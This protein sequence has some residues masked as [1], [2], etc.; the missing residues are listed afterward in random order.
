MSYQLEILATDALLFLLLVGIVG[1]IFY[2]RKHEHLK[3]P[4]RQV[5][6]RPMAMSALIVL[7]VYSAIGILDSIHLRVA[8][9][10]DAREAQLSQT[11]GIV[12]VL[13]IMLTTIRTNRKNLLRT[14]GHAGLYQGNR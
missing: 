7:L 14:T 13:D 5:F 6:R 8:Y 9:D 10:G 12:S 1:F 3:I 2:A 4:W 11:T